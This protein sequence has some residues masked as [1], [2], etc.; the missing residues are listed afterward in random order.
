MQRLRLQGTSLPHSCE[1]E[2][3]SCGTLFPHFRLPKDLNAQ[4]LLFA[5]QNN[6]FP[7][8]IS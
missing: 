7:L 1:Y 5:P 3:S 2:T 8:K 4:L 6:L